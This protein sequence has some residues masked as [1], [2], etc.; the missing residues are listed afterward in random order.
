MPEISGVLETALYVG[1]VGRSAAFYRSLFGF[2][3]MIQDDR[4]CAMNVAGKQVLLLFRRGGAKAAL[5]VP[6]GLIPGHDGSGET[7]FAF[8]I[9][10]SDLQPWEDRLTQHDAGGFDDGG[11]AGKKRFHGA[12]GR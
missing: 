8:S 9:P 4:F 7:H 1:D 10:A 6:G 11:G 12:D 2:E 3:V 5:M